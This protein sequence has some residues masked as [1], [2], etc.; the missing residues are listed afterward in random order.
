MID[1]VFPLIL[2]RTVAVALAIVATGMFVLGL[3]AFADARFRCF[4]GLPASGTC[5]DATSTGWFYLAASAALIIPAAIL[6][7]KVSAHD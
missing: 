4:D 1:P 5:R 2:A 6:W 3:V 7:R